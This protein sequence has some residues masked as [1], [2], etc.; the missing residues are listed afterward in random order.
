MPLSPIHHFQ[1][2]VS[3]IGRSR[4]FYGAML[5]RLGFAKVLEEPNIVEWKK[6]G[7]RIIIIQSPKKFLAKAYHRKQVGLNHIAFRAPSREAVDEFYQE[8]L[9][10]E[11]IPVLY[12]GAKE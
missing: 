11:K 7:I 9:V 4:K 6:S 3:D 8:F 12:G 2:N 1:I 5:D 10:S